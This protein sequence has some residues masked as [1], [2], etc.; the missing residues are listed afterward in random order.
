MTESDD[1]NL[2]WNQES[3]SLETNTSL[4]QSLAVKSDDPD[5]RDDALDM[6]AVCSTTLEE[7][8][9]EGITTLE[10]SL[11]TIKKTYGDWWFC[12]L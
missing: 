3:G 1:W 10:T 7:T 9:I 12:A 11:D 5:A 8:S 6:T 2:M 4:Q